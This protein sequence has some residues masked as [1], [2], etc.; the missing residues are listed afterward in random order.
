MSRDLKVFV[1]VPK[2]AGTSLRLALERE[3]GPEALAMDYG[4]QRPE[5]SAVIKK[6]IYEQKDMSAL[7][8]ALE[9]GPVQVICGHF[10]SEKYQDTFGAHNTL[11]FLRDPVQRL[12]S[13]YNHFVNHHR[14]RETF[15]T[16]YRNPSFI[17]RQGTFA[18][19]MALSDY[20]LV[21]LTEEFNASV[22]LVN[23]KCGWNLPAMKMN[24]G[25]GQ[26]DV[27]YQL[28]EKVEQEI[29]Q[30]NAEDVAAYARAVEV[31]HAQ[32]QPVSP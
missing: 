17:N 5:T 21:G 18:D 25:R 26:V 28:P 24:L 3:L 19:G 1:H 22:A 10:P 20:G 2:T 11:I 29:R 8:S 12:V 14:Y 7:A 13:E 31:F 23:E 27:P 6:Y 15:E 9:E 16:F 4:P 30:L 32:L